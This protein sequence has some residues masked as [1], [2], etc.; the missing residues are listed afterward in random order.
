MGL[1]IFSDT[2]IAQVL[3]LRERGMTYEQIARRVG[4]SKQWASQICYRHGPKIPGEA[5]ERM[6]SAMQRK[7]DAYVAL[8][9]CPRCL[10]PHGD[11]GLGK[12]DLDGYRDH[13]AVSR[14]ETTSYGE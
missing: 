12:C 9:R 13:Q 4:C 1:T 11:D 2:D 7:I 5:Q 8:P 14:T 10:I 6:S 3:K